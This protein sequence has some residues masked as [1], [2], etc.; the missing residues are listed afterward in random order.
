MTHWL[1]VSALRALEAVVVLRLAVVMVVV[2]FRAASVS[3][4]PQVA[5]RAFDVNRAD[6][7][8]AGMDILSRIA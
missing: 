6:F 8:V 4:R 2:A 1:D 3:R 5:E 7:V